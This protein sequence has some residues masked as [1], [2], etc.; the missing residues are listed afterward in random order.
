MQL[1]IEKYLE[2]VDRKAVLVHPMVIGKHLNEYLFNKR[3]FIFS[4]GYFSKQIL[5]QLL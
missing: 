5:V 3:T 2:Q 4:N 1:N